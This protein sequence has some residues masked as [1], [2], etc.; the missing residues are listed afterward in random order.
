MPKRRVN[1]SL[2]LLLLAMVVAAMG[3]LAIRDHLSI[4]PAIDWKTFTYSRMEKSLAQGRPV[5]MIVKPSF[6]LSGEITI[7]EFN[8]E[9]IRRAYQ[10]DQLEAMLLEYDDWQ[11]REIKNIFSRFGHTKYPMAFCFQP[12]EEP[13]RLNPYQAKDF[14]RHVQVPEPKQRMPISLL[15]LAFVLWVAAYLHWNSNLA[16]NDKGGVSDDGRRLQE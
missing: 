5:L 1:F 7:Q 12:N 9:P 11:E 15:I 3:S 14:L 16:E 13:I 2:S 6:A 8:Q 4:P 10:S